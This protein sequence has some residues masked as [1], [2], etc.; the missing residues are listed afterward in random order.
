MA[1]ASDGNQPK[2]NWRAAIGARWIEQLQQ[3]E[4]Q[5]FLLLSLLI[6]ALT[7]LAVVA[8]IVLTERLG[9]RL[10]PVGSAAWRRVL[11]P[12]A[13]SL[14]M[15]VLL[16]R[17]FP[18]ARGSGVPQ[19]KAALFAQNGFISL[20]TVLGKF[21]CTA[22]TLACGIPLGREGP[23]VQVGAG[24]GSVLGRALGL[25][26]EK[27][28]AL[29]PVGA[30]AAIAAAF[31]TPMAA[32]LFALEEVMGDLNA[33]ILG[34]VVLASATSWAMLRMLLG[35]NPLFQVPQYT[36]VHPLEFGIYALLG[37]AG[38][39]LSVAFTRLLLTMRKYFQH[40]PRKTWWW[41]PV[42]GGVTV[43]LMGWCVP[44][45]LGVGYSYV[46]NALNGSMTLKL[47]L[48]LV[49]LKLIGVTVSYAS[50][51]AGGIFG[52]SLFLGAMLGGAI[53]AVA[54]HLLPG[55]TATQGAYALVGMGAVFAGIVRAP[56]TSVLMIFEMTRDYA[57]IVP[58]MIA[59][60]TSLFIS[61][62][63]Q[64]QPIYEALAHQDGIHLPTPSTL[65]GTSLRTVAQVMRAP[66]QIFSA[67]MSVQDAFEQART[68]QFHI[69]PVA[70]KAYF[71]GILTMETLEHALADGRRAQP[72]NSI[73]ETLQVPHVH[74]DHPLHLALERMSTYHLDVLP[75]VHR[76]DIHKLEGVVT[77]RDL[78]D[79][80][81]VSGSEDWFGS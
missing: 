21:F 76:A 78:L 37:I 69:W 2:M 6:G 64:K 17:Y 25:R 23:S 68:S 9:M 74:T 13:G 72:L 28:K 32:V 4:E 53:G 27:V 57:V 24:I 70:D 19:T 44:Q 56:M 43:G 30:A 61:R 52:P 63:F 51:N 46:G 14:A 38:G 49:A 18:G 26:P 42:V 45:V 7:G 1:S 22:T 60:L 15:G 41:H 47:M 55:Y 67:Q 39:F 79:S 34:S 66:R 31:N 71:L 36:L 54:H 3:R 33:P 16:Y 20:R 65:H 81:G 12:V 80:Y 62:R 5:V 59:N 8:F 10:Y 40:L 73:M 50:G 48:L 58:L 77:L 35:N 29:I 11:I 75:V